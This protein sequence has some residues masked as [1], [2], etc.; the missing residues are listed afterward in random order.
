[1]STIE[2]RPRAARVAR[3]V[4]PPAQQPRERVGHDPRVLAGHGGHVSLLGGEQRHRGRAAAGT[5]GPVAQHALAEE[6]GLRR[7]REEDLVE[8]LRQREPGALRPLPLGGVSS[9]GR[10]R[11]PAVA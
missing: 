4:G 6:P 9:E 7:A 2:A 5:R 10:G 1:M 8:R 11:S 3:G